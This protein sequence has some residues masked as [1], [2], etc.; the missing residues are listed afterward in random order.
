MTQ[1]YQP[2]PAFVPTT[3]SRAANITVI[4]P[5]GQALPESF[6]KQDWAYAPGQPFALPTCLI[7]NMRCEAIMI[8]MDG[9]GRPEVLL[10][11]LPG[12]TATAFKAA[13][14]DKSW[15]AMGL[16]LNAHCKGVREALREGRFAAVAP[17][18]MKE[19]EVAGQRL[20]INSGCA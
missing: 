1:R 14:D 2:V 4:Q 15:S 13:E 12:G 19:I 16:L 20:R 8:D 6:L 17:G 5:A 3:Q 9:D 7:G 11:N 18:S 10:F